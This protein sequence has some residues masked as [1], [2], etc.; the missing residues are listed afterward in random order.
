M[1]II[2]ILNTY[3]QIDI[4]LSEHTHSHT[5]THA[6]SYMVLS[7]TCVF[8]RERVRGGEGNLFVSLRQGEKVVY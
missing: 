4:N 6:L 2:Y 5:H 3:V 8:V 1:H 7:S